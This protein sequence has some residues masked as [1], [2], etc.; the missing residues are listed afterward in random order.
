MSP[1]SSVCLALLGQ[2]AIPVGSGKLELPVGPRRSVIEV[3]TYKPAAYRDGPLILVFHGV[4]RNADT[5]RDHSRD[6]ADRLGALIAAPCFDLERFPIESYQQGGVVRNGQAV[7]RDEWTFSLIP[8]IARAILEHEGRS[9]SPYY[10]L[11]HSGGGQFLERLTG[12]ADTGAVRVIAANPG[13]HLWPTRDRPYPYGFGDLPSDIADDTALR[14]YL[15]QPLTI[16]LGTGDVEIDQHLDQS[17]RALGQGE[18]RLARGRNTFEFAQRVAAERGWAFHWRLIEAQDVRH[19]HD[20]MFNDARCAAALFALSPS[21]AV[22]H[23]GLGT[24]APESTL[25]SFRA[26]LDR[27]LGFEFDVRRTRDGQLVCLHDEKLDRTTNGT[28]K[29]TDW[30]LEEVRKLDAGRWFSADFAGERVP[31]VDEVFAL[32][33]AQRDLS[34]LVAVDIKGSDPQIEADLVE[35]AV[36]HQVLSRLVFIGRTIEEVEV[37]RRLKRANGA[38]RTARLVGSPAELEQIATD[39]DSDWAYARFIPEASGVARLH[40]AGRRIFL[41]GPAFAGKEPANWRAAA[42][43]RVDGILTDHPQELH[44]ELLGPRAPIPAK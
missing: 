40:A 3:F 29:V 7:P 18:H 17:E 21:S 1:V 9:G 12:F 23:R 8:E 34:V 43:S 5:Y 4:L 42:N 38:A 11:G 22:G 41:A 28:G 32:L 19:N 36:R 44:D 37:R 15:A 25:A 35:L 6:L 2:A 39:S 27:N 10:L 20:A 24:A 26:C 16:Y 14:R 30:S 33:A 13:T 31:T